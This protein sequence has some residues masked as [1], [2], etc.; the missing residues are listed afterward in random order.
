[1]K[2]WILD[3]ARCVDRGSRY[4]HVAL[5]A[6]G[7]TPNVPNPALKVR[8]RERERVKGRGGAQ[9]H[10]SYRPK[11]RRSEADKRKRAIVAVWIIRRGA[12]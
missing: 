1:M 2:S 11:K 8:S 3:A 10:V 5:A 12:V 9:L 7:R 4:V 6:R